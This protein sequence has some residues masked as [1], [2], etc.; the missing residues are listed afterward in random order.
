MR[1]NP[2]KCKEMII[3]FSNTRDLPPT[4]S[5][6]ELPLE[7]VKCH[8]VLNLPLQ[9][10]LKWNTFIEYIT[11]KA[12]NRLDIF[13][14]LKRN[15]VTITELSSVYKALVRSV[16][17][18]CAPVWHTPIPAFMSDEVEKVQKRAFPIFYSGNH[19]DEALVLSECSSLSE[20]R[21]FLCKTFEKIWQPISR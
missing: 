12:S 21:S 18:Y 17:E 14:V 7:R 20:S 15:A 1:L 9:S 6:G 11:S 13:R 3:F 19:Y 10:N 5:I 2:S 8:K 4:C 16:L